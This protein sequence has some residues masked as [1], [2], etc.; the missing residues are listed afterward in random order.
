MKR[1]ILST[2]LV[3]GLAAFASAQ[4]SGSTG[5]AT[6]SANGTSAPKSAKSKKPSDK[7][8]NREVYHF[9]NGQ[10]STP[11]GA[12]ATPSSVGGGYAALGKDTT[13]K[14]VSPGGRTT[15][16]RPA[17]L[18]TTASTA[19]KGAGTKKSATTKRKGNQ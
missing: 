17:G 19:N 16:L 18:S 8:N 6:G 12:E 1:V 2:V 14:A 13:A 4:S 15:D 5:A 11:T 3:V 7:L 10:R 9:N